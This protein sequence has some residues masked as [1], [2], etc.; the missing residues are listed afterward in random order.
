MLI[1]FN[2]YLALEL[3]ELV[4]ISSLPSP[5]ACILQICIT[6]HTL[7]IVSHAG[8]YK[9]FF[10]QK[11]FHKLWIIS[12]S[13]C[14]FTGSAKTLR[15]GITAHQRSKNLPFPG[16]NHCY[17]NTGSFKTQENLHSDLTPIYTDIMSVERIFLLLK[18]RKAVH[19]QFLYTDVYSL[20][21][22]ETTRSLTEISFKSLAITHGFQFW[23]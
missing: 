12:I 2:H 3:Q 10:L 1:S 8:K 17:H 15:W 21:L 11:V 5:P 14:T 19:Y 23:R 18:I 7:T 4:I 16:N 6:H 13:L 20:E 9:T 22:K